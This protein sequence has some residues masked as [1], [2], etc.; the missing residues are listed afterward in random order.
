MILLDSRR[1]VGGGPAEGIS[2]EGGEASPEVPAPQSADTSGP[3]VTTIAQPSS[4]TKKTG[5]QDDQGSKADGSEDVNPDDI[6]F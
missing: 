5:K 3:S 2:G 1:S 4:G 6:P